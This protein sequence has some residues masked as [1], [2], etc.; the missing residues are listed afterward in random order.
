MDL[1]VHFWRSH[2]IL[3][4]PQCLF[5]AVPPDIIGPQCPSDGDGVPTTL[6]I[7]RSPGPMCPGTEYLVRGIPHFDKV[8]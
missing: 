5:L 4:G 7:W 3:N 8:L 6:D 2:R 1:N